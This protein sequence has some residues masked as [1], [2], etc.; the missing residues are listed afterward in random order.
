MVAYVAVH[1]VAY[2]SSPTVY[3]GTGFGVS[4]SVTG[5]PLAGQYGRTLTNATVA[6]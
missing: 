1:I 3:E 5:G 2:L 6:S 4:Y